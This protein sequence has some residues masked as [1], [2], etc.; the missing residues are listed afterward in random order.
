MTILYLYAELMGYQIPV[1][2]EYVSAHGATIHLV[3]WDH[4]KLTPYEPKAVHKVKYY[5]RSELNGKSLLQ[6]GESVMPDI[7]YVSGWM[8]REYMYLCRTLKSYGI[9]IIAGSDSQW[10][11]DLKQTLGSL[12][13]RFFLKKSFTHIWVAGPYQFE[14]ARK[15]SFKKTQILFNCLTADTKL[16]SRNGRSQNDCIRNFLFVG[17]LERSKGL[18]ELADAWE[19][20]SEKKGWTLTIVGNGSLKELLKS[21]DKVIVKDF[22]QPDMLVNEFEVAGCF[23]LP[24]LSEPW[25]LV[26]HEAAA[27]GLPIV[28]SDACGATPVF[29]TSGYNGFVCEAGNKEDLKDKMLKIINMSEQQ[30]NRFSENSYK[31]SLQIS[32][33]IVSASFLSAIKT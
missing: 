12:Y 16:F 28:A 29:V 4:K 9:P 32:P 3:H 5:K 6:L 13:F 11:G 27:M 19:Q 7:V 24:S 31:K 30:L 21:K 2:E 10:R 25:A 33:A 20:I 8:D 22:L 15:L 17:R 14:Y 1:L 23:V 26:I 18:I